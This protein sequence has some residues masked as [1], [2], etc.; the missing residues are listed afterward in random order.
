MC[1]SKQQP[2]P[3]SGLP[4]DEELVVAKW[5]MADAYWI[6]S[7]DLQEKLNSIP[8]NPF[9]TGLL[10]IM[11]RKHT[12]SSLAGVYAEEIIEIAEIGDALII[13]Q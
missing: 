12:A 9:F 5:A 1:S 6:W 7:A 8:V 10:M 3:Q 13:H 11:V 2:T 4:T